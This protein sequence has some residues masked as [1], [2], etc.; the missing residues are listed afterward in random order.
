MSLTTEDRLLRLEL[1]LQIVRY[2]PLIN[3]LKER[4][5]DL[6]NNCGYVVEAAR[7]K[8]IEEYYDKKEHNNVV[9]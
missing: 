8:A 3:S 7:L 5:M 6:H 1:L 9:L 2:H 4:I